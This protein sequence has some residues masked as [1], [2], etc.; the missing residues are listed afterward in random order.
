MYKVKKGIDTMYFLRDEACTPFEL[1]EEEYSWMVGQL[2]AKRSSELKKTMTAY[3]ESFGVA[4][5]R[6]LVKNVTKEQ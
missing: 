5:L 3:M 6:A 4:E 1:S 2:R